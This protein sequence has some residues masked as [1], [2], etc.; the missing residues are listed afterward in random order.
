MLNPKEAR[1]KKAFPNNLE[2][3]DPSNKDTTLLGRKLTRRDAIG[4]AGKV[5]IGAGVAAVVAAGG[6]AAY[7]ASRPPLPTQTTTTAGLTTAALTPTVN[8][9]DVATQEPG[10]RFLIGNISIVLALEVS[11]IFDHGAAQAA[12]A[13]GLDY[14]TIDAG[15]GDPATSVAAARELISQ[16]AKGILSFA[17][18]PTAVP[19]IARLCQDNK[20][21]YS[22]WWSIQPFQYPW[23]TG[24]YYL[25]FGFQDCETDEL[26]V[27]TLLF[28]KLK[29][30]GNASAQVIN[31]QGTANLPSNAIKNLGITEAWQKTL[32]TASLVAHPYG[33][34][35]LATA[36]GAMEDALAIYPNIAG[37]TTVNDSMTAGAVLGA[38]D[39]GKNIG[40]FA[41]GVDGQTAFMK[42]MSEG[43]GLATACFSP[44][45]I[46]GLGLCELYDAITG[47]YY[48]PQKD[49]LMS[50]NDLLVV[51]DVN[52][53]KTLAQQANFQLPFK[54]VGAADYYN[55]VYPNDANSTYPWDWRLMS[56]GKARELGL[57]Y[58]ITG[59]TGWGGEHSF[60]DALGSADVFSEYILDCVN[61]FANLAANS[62]ADL[63]KAPYAPTA[64]SPNVST[65]DWY[66]SN[67][68]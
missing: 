35:D 23:N 61:R 39:K 68:P 42:M 65:Y 20:V 64:A 11:T 8:P 34:W 53:A 9:A 55:K 62:V 10:S 58:D 21:F 37:I 24:P 4:T 33:Q 52:E 26:T 66:K 60:V 2:K 47:A 45:Y 18:D 59:G 43:N 49:R 16:G 50:T 51:S 28:Q 29:N 36:K 13:L 31:I 40:G 41:T 56:R 32:P 7:F 14:K 15:G 63:S 19:Q 6:T 44:A 30:A 57:Q 46:Y 12:Q 3:I 38:Q 27:D 5:A 67:P 54:V 48:P 25:K 17:I 1:R 22:S